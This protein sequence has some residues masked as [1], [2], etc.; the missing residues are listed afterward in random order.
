MGDAGHDT[1]LRG[2]QQKNARIIRRRLG[3]ESRNLGR[4]GIRRGGAP[5]HLLAPGRAEAPNGGTSGDGPRGGGAG[6]SGGRSG[7]GGTAGG[8]QVNRAGGLSGEG[9]SCTVGGTCYELDLGLMLACNFMITAVL[10]PINHSAC[11]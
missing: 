5:A 8:E 11:G 10:F 2:L 7:G 6:G 1:P 9:P 4:L 3:P